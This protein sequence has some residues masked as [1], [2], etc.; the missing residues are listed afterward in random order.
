MSPEQPV[1]RYFTLLDDWFD[2]FCECTLAWTLLPKPC[3]QSELA[4]PERDRF[5][6]IFVGRET[7]Q[8]FGESPIVTAG[9]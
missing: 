9:K 7:A 6:G 2:A 4:W 1:S 8:K 3:S 5:R